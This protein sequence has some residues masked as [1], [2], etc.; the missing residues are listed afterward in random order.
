[1]EDVHIIFIFILLFD[2]GL[3]QWFG[4]P[5][6]LDHHTFII[7]STE[8]ISRLFFRDLQGLSFD[9]DWL[10][11]LSIAES[12]EGRVRGKMSLGFS[13]FSPPFSSPPRLAL[14]L[15]TIF[16]VFVGF[17]IKDPRHFHLL[18]ISFEEFHILCSLLYGSHCS[19]LILLVW[20]ASGRF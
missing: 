16:S 7:V 14:L 6:H 12:K 17:L 9:K 3:G 8:S 4:S 5:G 10:G 20:G 13:T 1:M 2:E 18:A 15:A 11:N 19:D